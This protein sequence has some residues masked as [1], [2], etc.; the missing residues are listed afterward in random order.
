[1]ILWDKL[2]FWTP[3]GNLVMG[4]LAG[5]FG[6]LAGSLI[7]IILIAARRFA[8]PPATP[9]PHGGIC[10]ACGTR[11][12]R[13]VRRSRV[14][15][16]VTVFTRRYPHRCCRCGWPSPSATTARKRPLA[17]RMPDPTPPPV[18]LDWESALTRRRERVLQ[19]DDVAE[20]RAA[21]LRY[22]AALNA[23][24]VTATAKCHLADFTDFGFDSG[25]LAL[26]RF[27]SRTA[28]TDLDAGRTYDLRCQDLRIY[29]HKDTAIATACLAGTVTRPDGAST[30]VAGRS[31]LVHLRQRGAWRIAHTHWSPLN[32]DSSGFS[33]LGIQKRDLVVLPD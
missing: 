24:D 32:P 19:S 20:V 10:P 12:L 15:R 33:G 6:L 21:V 26:D 11:S 13:R 16:L 22:L 30:A 29:I 14:Q 27:D 7:A 18:V 3:F 28:R 17:R 4:L 25:L 8:R 2:N 31:A 5:W 23:G 1:M 9:L